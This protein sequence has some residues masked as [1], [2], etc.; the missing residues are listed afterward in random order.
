MST[1]YVSFLKRLYN[2]IRSIE[3]L[4]Q[5]N[6]MENIINNVTFTEID[7]RVYLLQD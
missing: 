2:F 5:Y 4:K 6:K 1:K 3:P 7:T